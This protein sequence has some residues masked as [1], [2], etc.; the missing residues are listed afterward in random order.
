MKHFLKRFETDVSVRQSVSKYLAYA[1][2][3]V[4]I[5]CLISVVIL[6]IQ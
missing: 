5:L 6:A 1:M 4:M 2:G 3:V